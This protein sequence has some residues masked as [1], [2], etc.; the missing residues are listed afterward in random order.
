MRSCRLHWPF[1]SLQSSL[2][3]VTVSL[4][5][6]LASLPSYSAL[7]IRTGATAERLEVDLPSDVLPGSYTLGVVNP[8][9]AASATAQLL[10]GDQGHNDVC[11]ASACVSQTF[12]GASRVS[13][14]V[15][16]A[17]N[18]STVSE[19]SVTLD[20]NELIATPA[21]GVWLGVLD[22]ATHTLSS[23]SHHNRTYDV[24]TDLQGLLLELGNLSTEPD[25]LVMSSAAATSA[26]P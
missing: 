9:G 20:G 12:P 4:T 6:Q 17:V 19:V 5:G 26:R 14:I 25:K 18:G 24:T 11:D 10:K 2:T 7:V 1:S 16:R 22:R 15:A 21:D 13:T 8:Y 23:D 3:G